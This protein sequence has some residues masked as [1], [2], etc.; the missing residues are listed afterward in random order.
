M[1]EARA[2]IRR[3][4]PST[5]WKRLY[6]VFTP[7][8]GLIVD[9]VPLG[10]LVHAGVLAEFYL[11]GGIAE[12]DGRVLLQRPPERPDALEQRLLGRVVASR[13]VNWEKWIGDDVKTGAEMARDQLVYEG[14]VR[15]QQARSLGVIRYM[16][17]PVSDPASAAELRA[18]VTEILHRAKAAEPDAGAIGRAALAVLPMLP[19]DASSLPRRE[20]RQLLAEL[21]QRAEAEILAAYPNM[22]ARGI[23]DRDAAFVALATRIP[24]RNRHFPVP[25][26]CAD[27]CVELSKRIAPVA[28]ALSSVLRTQKW[29]RP[30][31]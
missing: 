4:P 29:R 11:A 6:L 21:R 14:L 28:S 25:D 18:S 31:V 12:G 5:L 7:P 23:D 27:L 24:Y 1:A 19:P 2:S 30:L 9:W 8:D 10:A 17:Y 16:T 22:N 20:R 26:D 15:A 13:S 3:V